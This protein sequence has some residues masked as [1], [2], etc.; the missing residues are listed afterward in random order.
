MPHVP[1]STHAARPV[2][3]APGRIP[4]LGAIGLCLLLA[5]RP[6]ASQ[7]VDSS[8]VARF[9][10]AEAYLRG[11]QFDRAIALLEDL[12]AESPETHV[13]FDR[14]RQ[15]YENVKRYDDAIRLI[16]ARIER[17]ETPMA[18]LAE[19]GRL[20]YLKGDE[21]GARTTWRT[22]LDTLPNHTNTYLTVYRAML[23]VRLFDEAID[24]LE[25]GRRTL[26]REDLFQTDLAYLYN[27]TGEH[28]KAMVEYLNLL[29]QNERQLNFV[30]SRLSRYLEQEDALKAS[31]AVAE[32][33]VRQNPLNRA[34][35][36]LL[37]WL[38]LE[39]GLYREALNVNR[40]IDRLEQEQGQVLF[41]FARQAADAG[42]YDVAL[43]A[44]E[45]ILAR[46]PGAPAAPE[47]QFGLAEMYERRAEKTGE[48]AFD[49]AGNRI[50]APYYDNALN[51][52]RAFLQTYPHHP[53]YPDVLRRIGRLQQDVFIDLGAAEATLREV[54]DRY[55]GTEAADRAEYDLGRI[56]LQQNRLDAARLTFSRLI[57][58]LR[59]GELAELA[60][61][62]LALIHFYQGEFDAARTILEAMK[63][64]TSADVANDAIELKVLLVENKGP[65][66]LDTPLRLYARAHL[67]ERQRRPAEALQTLESLLERYGTHPLADD[68]RFSRAR[69]L[70]RLGRTED[71]LIAL[72]EL[73]LLHPHSYL[74][75]RSLFTAAQIQEYDL[76]QPEAARQTYT[77][78]LTEYPSSLLVPEARA[79]I[80]ALRGDGT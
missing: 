75:D 48:Q 77:R 37:S 61:Y 72:L 27:L 25:T 26:G 24:V 66:S 78:L 35:R 36:E 11:A 53:L 65:D 40:A 33:A 32:R 51:A 43:E 69:L 28:A 67:L 14:L 34:F 76:G 50:P 39:A 58:R 44:Y 57:D 74:A 30:R 70:R 71:A 54:A 62:E 49:A 13:F 2:F 46:Y 73:P 22:A 9:Q 20:L 16:D 68:T 3:R 15:A 5:A 80:R 23:Q 10:L 29:A 17:T 19:K 55:A 45:E 52:Y 7:G 60:R 31:I 12:Y 18:L 1:F 21:E 56:A 64:N 79:R 59:T 47:A 63:E 6:A 42:A 4:L 38:Y 8:L 41:D